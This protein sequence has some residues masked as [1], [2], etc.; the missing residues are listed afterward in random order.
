LLGV[1]KRELECGGSEGAK[2]AREG[3][4]LEKKRGRKR[5]VSKRRGVYEG[6]GET[7]PVRE[8]QN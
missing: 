6:G 5:V 4:T 2:L 1:T 3:A 7:P 8:D